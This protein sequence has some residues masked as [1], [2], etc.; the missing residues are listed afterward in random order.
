MYNAD[1]FNERNIYIHNSNDKNRLN[2]SKT[3]EHDSSFAEM[4]VKENA[5]PVE[6]YKEEQSNYI[7]AVKG[8]Q[9]N[10]VLQNF[11]RAHVNQ[12]PVSNPV[13]SALE[14]NR[15]KKF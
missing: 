9:D 12:K 6:T 15:F 5:A 13:S 7:G 4:K 10:F 14:R 2:R 3:V 8:E 11:N 1:G